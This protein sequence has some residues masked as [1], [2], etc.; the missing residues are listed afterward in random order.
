[1]R[2]RVLNGRKIQIDFASRECQVAFFDHLSKQ[3]HP[4]PAERPWER[5]ELDKYVTSPRYVKLTNLF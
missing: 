5:R 1:M 3:G 2:G 4:L